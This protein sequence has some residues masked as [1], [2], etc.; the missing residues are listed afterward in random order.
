MRNLLILLLLPVFA[1]HMAT[2]QCITAIPSNAVV[3]NSTQTINGGFDPIWVCSGDT[4]HSDGGFHKIVLE[5]GAVMTTSGG[6]DSI[7]VNQ[8]AQFFM[9]G[10]IHVIFFVDP[11]DLSIT[12]GIPTQNSCTSLQ[13]DYSTAPA[14]GCVLTVNAAFAASDSSVCTGNC[15]DFE[16]LS[17][18]ATTWQWQF[19]GA[20]PASSSAENPESICYM[21]PGNYNVTLITG[22][23]SVSDTLTLEGFIEASPPPAPPALSQNED[24][25]FATEGYES[26]QWYFEGDLISGATSYFYVATQSGIYSVSVTSFK[27]CGSASA[28]ISFVFTG[29]PYPAVNAYTLSVFPNPAVSGLNIRVTAKTNMKGI[30][31]IMDGM[32]RKIY[33]MDV[34][35]QPGSHVIPLDISWLA[36]GAYV[37]TIELD[38]LKTFKVL[39]V[40]RE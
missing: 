26:Y 5:P 14:N 17:T 7:Y 15:I 33:A 34:V 37:V 18:N 16:S 35:I 38:G 12:G 24:T 40:A 27:G 13:I 20:N 6:I 2:A 3:V 29:M 9:N 10:G 4:L 28:E 19:P 21:V 22:N 8:S 1:M 25:L 31:S 32:G 11:A 23:G 39:M 36:A 30:L